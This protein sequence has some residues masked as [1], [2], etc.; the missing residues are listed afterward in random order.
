MSIYKEYSERVSGRF[1][2][3][4]QVCQVSQICQ[5]IR[6]LSRCNNLIVTGSEV[7]RHAR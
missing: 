1:F 4:Y 3:I 2:I 5:E 7:V 6:L